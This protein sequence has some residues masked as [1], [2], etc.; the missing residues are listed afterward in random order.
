MQRALSPPAA[1]AQVL[2]LEA[3]F[4]AVHW[5]ETNRQLFAEAI[6]ASY[7]Q[8]LDCPALVGL[9]TIDEII[10][11]HMAA[12]QFSPELWWAVRHGDDPVGVMLLSPLPQ[13][14]AMELVYLG[15]APAWRG[16]G[17]G[18]RLLGHGLA[19][20]HQR[21]LTSMLLA[22][23]DLNKPAVRLYQSQGFEVH[24]KKLAMIMALS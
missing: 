21:G 13:R 12:G 11:G 23:D 20:A 14:S 15:L 1:E 4:Q 2:S 6:L 7:Q 16:R 22:V 3:G 19:Q 17:L 5:S 24:A 8:T 9:R 18:S 10:E